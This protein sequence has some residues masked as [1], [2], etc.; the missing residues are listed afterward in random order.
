MEDDARRMLRV[1]EADIK[2]LD[3]VILSGASMDNIVGGYVNLIGQREGLKS[4]IE[5]LYE[6]FGDWLPNRPVKAEKKKP[7]TDY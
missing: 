5:R 6:V 7:Y 3:E 4:A 2:N 1:L